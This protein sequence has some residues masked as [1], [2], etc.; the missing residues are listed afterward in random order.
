[1]FRRSAIL[2]ALVVATFLGACSIGDD[3]SGSG[4]I[5][6]KEYGADG[7]TRIVLAAPGDL[8]IVR[9][10]AEK[11]VVETDDN[12][13]EHVEVDVRGNTL[14]IHLDRGTWDQIRPTRLD[15]ELE[16]PALESIAVEGSGS[17][18]AGDLEMG[19]LELTVSGS[20]TISDDNVDC[21][22]LRVGISGSGMVRLAGTCS[23]QEI[24]VSGSGSFEAFDLEVDSASVRMSGSGKAAVWVKDELDA[25]VSGSGSIEYY[26]KPMVDSSTSGSG[27]VRSKG[28]K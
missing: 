4:D 21:E 25:N 8:R 3:L 23:D 22:S 1:M 2:A 26:G 11:L 28:E 14:E 7:V 18:E 9:G 16:I 17:V 10:D 6:S 27:E 12:V 13:M 24:D 5:E 15:L 20:G 19:D